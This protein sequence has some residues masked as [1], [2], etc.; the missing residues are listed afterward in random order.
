MLISVKNRVTLVLSALVLLVSFIIH[1]LHR[2]LNISEIWGHHPVEQVDFITNIFLFIPIVLFGISF[3]LY[4]NKKDHRLLPLFNTLT[5]TFSSISMIAGGEGMVEY[6][7]SIFMVVA[8]IGYYER[9]HLIVVM[10]LIFAVQ[11]L[12][13]FFFMSEYVFGSNTYS[14]SMMMMHAIFL[15][16]T[17]GAIIWQTI[18]KQK[19]LASFDE[20]EEKQ[21]ILSGIMEQLSVA[22]DKLVDSSSQ[23]KANYHSN[24]ETMGDIVSQIKEIS[25]EADTQKEQTVNSADA[26]QEIAVGI[27]QIARTSSDVSRSSIETTKEANKGN[28]KMQEAVQQMN[29]ISGTVSETSETIKLLHNRSQEIGKIVGSMTEI[30]SQTDLLALNAA[31]EASRAGEY[32]RGFAVVAGEV[33]K[34]ADQSA[35]FAREITELIQTIQKD[36]VTS[37]DSMSK[38]IVEVTEGRN[39]VE[40]TGQIFGKITHSIEGVTEQVKQISLSA[41]EQS[42]TTEQAAA[43]VQEMATF[44]ELTTENAQQAADSSA[45]QLSSTEF[46][47]AL[48]ATLSGIALELEELVN[49][50]EELK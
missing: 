31:I 3:Y 33:R 26:I 32:G 19:L 23:L 38:V 34:L 41:E 18:N 21:K 28:T 7:F 10:T 12:V 27:Q 4:N 48:I 16:G 22:A 35:S 47:S 42:A 46:L 14:F 25:K 40:E 6:H 24:Q 43:S 30:A 13:G 45:V 29:S 15:I 36:T 9:I 1:I 2:V 49:K 11:H 20:T 44:A 8:M 17:S 37:A 50:T 39:I 5:I